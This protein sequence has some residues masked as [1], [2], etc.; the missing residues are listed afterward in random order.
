[1]SFIVSLSVVLLIG[2]NINHYSVVSLISNPSNSFARLQFFKMVHM[3]EYATAKIEDHS[4]DTP[5][6]SK[7]PTCCENSS[8][9]TVRF[10]QQKM[11]VDKYQSILNISDCISKNIPREFGLS[12]IILIQFPPRASSPQGLS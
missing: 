1:M 10:S 2:E 7:D 8:R 5:K 4:S 12:L 11:S 6:F 9:K 3:N